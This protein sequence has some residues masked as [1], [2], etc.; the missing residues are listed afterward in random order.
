MVMGDRGVCRSVGRAQ[1][2]FRDFSALKKRWGDLSRLGAAPIQCCHNV[3]IVIDDSSCGSRPAALLSAAQ[4]PHPGALRDDTIAT[5]G[6]CITPFDANYACIH[7]KNVSRCAVIAQSATLC[8]TVRDHSSQW[9]KPDTESRHE[10]GED[11][12]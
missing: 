2:K 1:L 9:I 11:A 8:H 10:K 6:F 3:I 4:A 5:I 12:I 7:A